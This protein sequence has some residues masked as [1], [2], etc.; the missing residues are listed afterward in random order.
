MYFTKQLHAR[1][2]LIATISLG[3]T[4]GCSPAS[5]NALKT[6]IAPLPSKDAVLVEKLGKPVVYQVFTRLFGNKNLPTYVF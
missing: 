2:L 3:A 6:D 4:I 5:E 1:F